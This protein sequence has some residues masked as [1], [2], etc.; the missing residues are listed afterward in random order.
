MTQQFIILQSIVTNVNNNNKKKKTVSVI[1]KFC[2][3]PTRP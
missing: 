2:T 1:S 3:R